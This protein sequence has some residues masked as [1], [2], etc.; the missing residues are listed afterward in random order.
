MRPSPPSVLSRRLLSRLCSCLLNLIAPLTRLRDRPTSPASVVPTTF[1]SQWL[2]KF[3]AK[4]S[5]DPDFLLR[6]ADVSAP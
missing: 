2:A 4:F 1:L 3:E 6:I 5:A